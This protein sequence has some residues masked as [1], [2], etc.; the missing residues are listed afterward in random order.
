M[1]RSG[2]TDG[3]P[4]AED[5]VPSDSTRINLQVPF[6]T[7]RKSAAGS[8]FPPSGDTSDRRE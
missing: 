4:Y 8:S 1:G 5:H 7:P 2:R 6:T 3:R